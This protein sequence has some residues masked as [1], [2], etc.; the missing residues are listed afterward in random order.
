MMAVL[1]YHKVDNRFELGVTTVRPEAFFRQIGD[2]KKRGY[3]IRLSAACDAGGG[4]C[5]TFDDGYDCF[6]RN[7]VPFLT[8]LNVGATVFIITDFIGKT[9]E[10]DLRLSYKP[11]V[12]MDQRQIREVAELGFEVGS[13]SC[14]HKDLTRL[15]RSTASNELVRSKKQ[16][17]DMIGREVRSV[18][19]P[20]GRHN[21]E[22]A[23]LA[24]EAGY[25]MLYGLGSSVGDGVIPRM[26][27]YRFDNS[28]AVRRKVEMNR[29]EIVKG[30]L[31]HSFSYLSALLSVRRA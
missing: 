27:V 31:V 12:H 3:E 23:A 9:N 11:F 28:A 18:S 29:I 25:E 22:V 6:Y 2:L 14:S 30:D 24:R 17:E 1:A 13:H 16:I 7:V 10:W 8:S 20:F 5:L 19:F 21:A 15:S 4:V 26:P